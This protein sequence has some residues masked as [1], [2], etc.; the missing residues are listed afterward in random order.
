MI[1]RSKLA[2]YC[3]ITGFNI[4]Q[5]ERD[6]MQHLFL[7]FL[8]EHSTDSLVF[9]GGTALQ[10]A[11][12]LNRASV[13]L[14]FS[15]QK[16]AQFTELM[17]KISKSITLFGYA[18]AVKE[19]KTL[20]KTF[21]LKIEG[22][23]FTGS[24]ISL[25]SLRIEISQR[26]NILLK[27]ELK[28]IIPVY[29]DLRPYFV[30]VMNET[31]IFAEKVRAIMT[32]NKPR[33]VFDLHFLIRRGVK[34]DI[35]FIRKKLNYYKEKYEPERFAAKLKEKKGI[36]ENEMKKYVTHL[37]DFDTVLAEIKKAMLL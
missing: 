17:Q 5:A 7:L 33:D 28:E 36:W 32:R 37:P 15:Q 22:P 1:D 26:E 4:G 16:D 34:P 24:P 19:I 6:Y 30:L 12:G 10:K 13:D 3:T 18:T 9:K 2:E 8:S 20:G 23:L 35:M 14:D 11:Y 31:E 27:P 21:L 25:C 29:N